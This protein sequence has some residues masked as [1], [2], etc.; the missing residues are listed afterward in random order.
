[1]CQGYVKAFI[2]LDCIEAFKQPSFHANGHETLHQVWIHQGQDGDG[3]LWR[4]A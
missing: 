2:G 3:S 4:L 1:M